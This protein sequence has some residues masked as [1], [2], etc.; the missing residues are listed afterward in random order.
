MKKKPGIIK[1]VST[2]VTDTS[3]KFLDRLTAKLSQFPLEKRK[4]MALIFLAA[5][6]VIILLS[7]LLVTAKGRFLLDVVYCTTPGAVI[8][9]FEN[10]INYSRL[11]MEEQTMG[12]FRAVFWGTNVTWIVSGIQSLVVNWFNGKIEELTESKV[13]QFVHTILF[14][15]FTGIIFTALV[16]YLTGDSS[17]ILWLEKIPVMKSIVTLIVTVVLMFIAVIAFCN[18]IDN[19][20]NLLLMIPATLFVAWLFGFVFRAITGM[21]AANPTFATEAEAEA[22]YM[23]DVFI[24]G[25]V[26]IAFLAYSLIVL[27][28]KG[29]E[30][31]RE[32]IALEE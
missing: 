28:R 13:L 15:F 4:N 1:T 25:Y 14:T 10:I 20:K 6:L 21:E 31:H 27:I 19:I 23:S 32:K 18:M 26:I 16:T 3:E 24:A 29:R 11:P 22:Y 17:F 2:V 7:F 8:A 30:Q 5:E 12:F 9:I